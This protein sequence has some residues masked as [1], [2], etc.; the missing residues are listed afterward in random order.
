MKKHFLDKLIDDVAIAYADG[1]LERVRGKLRDKGIALIE[2][3]KEEAV[4]DCKA[5]LAT[6]QKELGGLRLQLS[7]ME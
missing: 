6:V 1:E 2:R 5:K 3:E 4:R 7:K